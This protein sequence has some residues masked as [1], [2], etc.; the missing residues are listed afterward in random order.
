[1]NDEN[2]VIDNALAT[3]MYVTRCVIS[4]SIRTTPGALVYSRDMIM[5]VSLIANLTSIR[6]G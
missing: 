5:N 3:V 4:T 2:Q 6:D 1:M